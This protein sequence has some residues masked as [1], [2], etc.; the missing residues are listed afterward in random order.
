MT[1]TSA[2]VDLDPQLL[3]ALTMVARKPIRRFGNPWGL[4]TAAATQ[5]LDLGLIEA[6]TAHRP[7][8]P[9]DVWE[10]WKIRSTGRAALAAADD[11]D[12]A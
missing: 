11:G 9:S 8:N 1:S 7:G 3:V 2:P 6:S 12:S 10:V 4:G 5:L